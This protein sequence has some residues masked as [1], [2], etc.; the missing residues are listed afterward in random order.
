VLA[1]PVSVPQEATSR[2]PATAS[3][4]KRFISRLSTVPTALRN[5]VKRLYSPR[6]PRQSAHPS[7]RAQRR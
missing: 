2:A 7:R 5:L 6:A 3:L 1:V 4:A